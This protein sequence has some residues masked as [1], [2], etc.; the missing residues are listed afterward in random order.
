[1]LA[2]VDDVLV[3]PRRPGAS[4]AAFRMIDVRRLLLEENR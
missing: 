4:R 2:A 1:V 3:E